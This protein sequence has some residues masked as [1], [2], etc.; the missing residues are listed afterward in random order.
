MHTPRAA[1]DGPRAEEWPDRLADRCARKSC[2]PT[3]QM[4]H[5]LGRTGAF[6]GRRVGLRVGTSA[7]VIV[8]K[9]L[10]S[11]PKLFKMQ[12]KPPGDSRVRSGSRR[13]TRPRPVGA[14]P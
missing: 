13:F 3:L 2:D 14:R 5:E 10:A 1:G 11:W 8:V 9:S 4:R 12:P 7:P 6:V